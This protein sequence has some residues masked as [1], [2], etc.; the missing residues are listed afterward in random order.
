MPK[1]RKLPIA[2]RL[3]API[4]TAAAMSLVMFLLPKSERGSSVDA[5]QSKQGE[6]DSGK[7]RPTATQWRALMTGLSAAIGL[8]P[9]ALSTGIGSQVQQPLACVIV[10][11]MALSP[12]CSLLAI[13]IFARLAMPSTA[14]TVER[15]EIGAGAERHSA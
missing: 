7:F 13:P 8:L 9:A 6:T 12:I 4:T 11:G 3:A 14:A 5:A 10:G 2:W 1:R 15:Q